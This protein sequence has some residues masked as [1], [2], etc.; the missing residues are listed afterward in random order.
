MQMMESLALP[1]GQ[2]QCL[3]D[4]QPP[5]YKV[6]TFKE[7][8]RNTQSVIMYNTR[9]NQRKKKSMVK[10]KHNHKPAEVVILFIISLHL[11][12]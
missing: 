1:E 2:G 4:H 5:M 11:P 12:T 7:I 9:Q 3:S 6:V 8:N 10:S